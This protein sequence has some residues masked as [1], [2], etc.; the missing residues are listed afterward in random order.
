MSGTDRHVVIDDWMDWIPVTLPRIT[1]AKADAGVTISHYKTRDTSD[2][3]KD[4]IGT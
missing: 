2:K 3:S 1:Q 4:S